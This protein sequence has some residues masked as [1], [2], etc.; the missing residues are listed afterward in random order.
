MQFQQIH[1]MDPN[2]GLEMEEDLSG[3][4]FAFSALFD[5]FMAVARNLAHRKAIKLRGWN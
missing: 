3:E 2:S 4:Q 1:S 5:H